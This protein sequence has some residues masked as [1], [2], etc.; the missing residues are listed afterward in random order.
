M[1][2]LALHLTC[3]NTTFYFNMND[4]CSFIPPKQ[5]PKELKYSNID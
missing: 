3:P 4:H 2:V 5:G 1:N